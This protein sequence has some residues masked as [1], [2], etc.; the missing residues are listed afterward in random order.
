[1]LQL[2]VKSWVRDQK[3]PVHFHHDWND[4][5]IELKTHL[6]LTSEPMVYLVNLSEKDYIR[7]KNWL[8][9]IKEWVGRSGP[10]ALVIPFSGAWELEWQELSAEERQ[11]HL[12]AHVTQSALPQTMKAEGAAPSQLEYFLTAAPEVHAWTRRGM[13]A[14]QAAGKSHTD[15]QKG[16]TMAEVMKYEDFKEEDSENAVK[17]AGKYRQQGRNYI[18]GDGDI[19]FFKFNTPQ[20]YKRK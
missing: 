13:K 14:P 16:F 10:G 1:E 18:V 6:L 7:K 3:K 15:F 2:K 19:M 17:A 12:E 4:K 8:I 20:Q 9:K 5:E 11:K